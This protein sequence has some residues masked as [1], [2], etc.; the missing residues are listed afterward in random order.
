MNND[1]YLQDSECRSESSTFGLFKCVSFQP[2]NKGAG[3]SWICRKIW[4]ARESQLCSAPKPVQKRHLRRW[5]V[6]F[7][8]ALYSRD[9]QHRSAGTETENCT[10]ADLLSAF[11]RKTSE[12]SSRSATCIYPR[13]DLLHLRDIDHHPGHKSTAAI[14]NDK[15][16]IEAFRFWARLI[17]EKT[18]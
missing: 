12:T 2:A 13:D 18:V 15:E 4:K 16:H 17:L 3:I 6:A 7:S 8:E 10:F 11:P 1:K 9:A 14:R 5:V